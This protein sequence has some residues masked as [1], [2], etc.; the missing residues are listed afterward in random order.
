MEKVK[1]K[2]GMKTLFVL[3]TLCS[4]LT[5][6]VNKAQA[7]SENPAKKDIKNPVVPQTSKKVAA[8]EITVTM[9]TSRCGFPDPSTP[10]LETG[11]RRFDVCY[12]VAHKTHVIRE[13]PAD[14]AWRIVVL[15]NEYLRVEFA[16]ELGGMIWRLFDKVHN[17]DVLHKPGKVSPTMDGFGGTYT[18]GGLE[19]NYPYAHS[20]TNTWPRKTE[21][22]ENNDGSAT[23]TV[24][25]WERNGRTEWCMVFTVKPGESRLKQEV[26]LYNRGKLPASFVYWGNARVPATTDTHWIEPEAMVSEHG[27]T[28]V[29]TW[30]V[31]RDID[32]SLLKNDPEIIGM[33]F[34]EP[35][36]NFFGLNNLKTGSGMVHFAEHRDVPG[37]KLWNWGRQP[38]D[39]NRKW[40]PSL[41]G[42]IWEGEPHMFGY[43]YGEVQSGRMVNQEHLEWL[44]PEE[45][46]KW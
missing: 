34:L 27:G 14:I 24:S 44:M 22:K 1:F 20:V 18:P 2:P 5:I 38:M 28:H 45:C 4:L 13:K 10:F 17:V 35:R 40:N 25:E 33:Y 8:K 6:S 11:G 42:G 36:Y 37:K 39:G 31:F 46:I 30:P 9:P 23:Y 16:P 43:N 41:E 7:Q 21:F 26:T 29:F 15:E 3:L 19:L 32:F 12:P